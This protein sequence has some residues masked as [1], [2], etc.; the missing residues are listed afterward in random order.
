MDHKVYYSQRLGKNDGKSK[1]NLEMLRKIY[2]A[3]FQHFHDKEY[4]R[5]SI[6][7]YDSNS[8]NYVAGELGS[9]ESINRHL[10]LKLRKE[11]LWPIIYNIGE[12]SEE[13]LFDIIEFCYDIISSP[14]KIIIADNFLGP[15]E[16]LTGYDKTSGQKEY[17]CELNRHLKDYLDGYELDN[18]GFI[19]K[20]SGFGLETLFE[21]KIPIEDMKIIKPIE[22]AVNKYRRRSSTINDRREA[23]RDLVDVLE[24]LRPKVTA[25]IHKKDDADLFNIA[26]NFGIR[27]HN[28]K[29][30]TDYNE[31]I[32][33]SWMFYFYLSTIHA[34]IRIINENEGT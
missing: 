11:N 14:N 20:T 10:L 26:N 24:Y 8:G 4:F 15:Y 33:L 2:L 31:N 9:D 18:N 23:V 5:E 6:G 7:F 19:V 22:L 28:E 34:F 32:W 25:Y 21:A 13:D 17:Q 12:Y 29:Q 1:I 30:K 16:K 3:L 27:H